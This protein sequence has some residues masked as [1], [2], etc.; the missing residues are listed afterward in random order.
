MIDVGPI[1]QD[2]IANGALVLVVT[3]SLDGDFLPE[4]EVRGGL[5]RSQAA[6]LP[7][8]MAVDAVTRPSLWGGAD[9]G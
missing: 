5:L 7:L 2:H 1:G 8:L 3:V 6:S 9:H 4:G